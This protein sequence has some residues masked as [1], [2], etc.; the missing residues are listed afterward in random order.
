MYFKGLALKFELS[1]DTVKHLRGYFVQWSKKECNAN[2][3]RYAL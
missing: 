2:F 1:P 3:I